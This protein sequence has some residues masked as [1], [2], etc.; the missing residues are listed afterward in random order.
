MLRHDE[1][2]FRLHV[3]SAG[4]SAWIYVY[5]NSSD[6]GPSLTKAHYHEADMHPILQA[7]KDCNT[8]E[9]VLALLR[10][11]HANEE[12]QRSLVIYHESNPKYQK[13]PNPQYRLHAGQGRMFIGSPVK[14]PAHE[15]TLDELIKFVEMRIRDQDES[16]AR[17]ERQNTCNIL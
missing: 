5:Q 4:N 17:M 11:I 2:I 16:I 6:N 9:S 7:T 1:K 10:N 13:H 3:S 14:D 12:C 15:D 8:C